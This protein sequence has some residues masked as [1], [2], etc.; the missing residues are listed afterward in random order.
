[1]SENLVYVFCFAEESPQIEKHEDLSGL[2]VIQSQGWYAVVKSVSTDDYS[3]ENLKKNFSDLAWVEAQVREHIRVIG[4]IMENSPV[5]PCKFGTLFSSLDALNKFLND[6]SVSLQESLAQVKGRE[7][8]SVKV[9]SYPETVSDHIAQLSEKVQDLDVQINDSSP[10]RSFLLK[11]KRKELVEQEV[12]RIGQTHGQKCFDRLSAISQLN[13]INKPLSKD[14]SGREGEM[15]LNAAFMVEN[16]KV[17]EFIDIA[18]SLKEEYQSEGFDLEY[19]GPWPPFNFITLNGS[20][21]G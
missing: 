14:L 19:T 7:E 12:E 21:A 17:A 20:D 8:W 16:D 2:K 9:F 3:E 1:M 6:Y 15:V 11:K 18:K 10:G 5:I 4:L 13:T